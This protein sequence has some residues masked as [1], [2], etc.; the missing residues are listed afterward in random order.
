MAFLLGDNNVFSHA[1]NLLHNIYWR[2][3]TAV[4]MDGNPNTS[5][6]RPN[7]VDV[8]TAIP[9][10]RTG[11]VAVSY[12]KRYMIVWGGYKQ[13]LPAEEEN[14]VL[15]STY[16]DG[17]ELWIYNCVTEK[18]FCKLC[19]G[20]NHPPGMSGSTAVIIDSA[21]YLFGGYDYGGDGC[22]NRLFKLDL[23]AFVWESLSPSG[24][25]PSPVD[26]MVGWQYNKRF[27]IFGG[28]GNP[29]C[30][31]AYDFQFVFYNMLWRGWTNQFFMYD[32]A[33]N[34]WSRPPCSGNFPS[35]R[36]AHAAAVLKDKVYI[37][38]GRHDNHRL[39]DLHSL[40][41]T[42][43]TWSGELP[44][45]GPL[46]EGRSWHSLTSVSDRFLILYGGFSQTN[47]PLKDCWMFDTEAE[48]WHLIELPISKPRLWHSA[49]L[50]LYNEV[51]VYGGCTSNILDLDR[52]PDQADDIIVI[53]ISPMSL[54]RICLE[55]V[56][57]LRELRVYWMTLPQNVQVSLHHKM[58]GSM[59]EYLEGS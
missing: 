22:T 4:S 30:T 20:I 50:S 18:W 48:L 29:D 46:P 3:I 53:R 59:T 44:V 34:Q 42:L 41:M 38:G 51:L 56:S 1:V 26:K 15:A 13:N 32:P 45:C 12:D 5:A 54:Y 17:K 24:T 37:F 2:L 31:S 52:K 27:Y 40:D 6:C 9:P 39:N 23:S 10:G 21:L 7:N 28:F 14:G 8:E 57:Q 33:K 58:G 36:A 11:H 16:F 35:A 19:S 49:C 55:K 43:L 47:V 25:P